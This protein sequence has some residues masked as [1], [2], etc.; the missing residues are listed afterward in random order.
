M[1]SLEVFFDILRLPHTVI[2]NSEKL[3]HPKVQCQEPK[4]G[5]QKIQLYYEDDPLC[6][7]SYI[8]YVSMSVHLHS[9]HSL[10][11][12]QYSWLD[13]SANVMCRW[14]GVVSGLGP[15][16][17]RRWWR[18][19]RGGGGRRAAPPAVHMQC[20]SSSISIEEETDRRECQGRHCCLWDGIHS[21][22]CRTTDLAPW[23]FE[24]QPLGR[25]DASELWMFFQNLFFKSS[26]LVNG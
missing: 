14:E 22:P 16:A 20:I 4:T 12:V 15:P 5:Q 26:L 6:P 23:W 21:I 25:K 10:Y 17:G 13:R 18:I 11:T 7:S 24:E 3:T 2:S 9:A 19:W 8:I 1:V